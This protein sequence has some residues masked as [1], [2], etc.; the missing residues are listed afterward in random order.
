MSAEGRSR[1][2]AGGAA[3]PGGSLSTLA[4]ALVAVHG[5]S[6]QHRL[7]RQ[8]AQR[9][10]LDRFAGE[11]VTAPAAGL[12]GRLPPAP[13]RR[14]SSSHEVVR[15][16]RERAR[17]ADLLRLGLTRSRRSARS[18]ARTSHLAAEEQRLG[19]ADTLRTAAEQAREALS[20]DDGA[21]DALGADG[22]GPAGRW[23]SVREHDPQVAGLADRLAEAS[24]PAEPT[25]PP[26]W[27]PTPRAWRPTRPG[28]RRSPSGGPR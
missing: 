3:V 11:P 6:D 16:A 28:W 14:A 23:T 12:R 7:L 17:E 8:E 9:D 25:S 21:A 10:A 13:G 5:Q 18:P 15:S 20:S 26:T 1:A 4:D 24:L 19:F 27:R 22:G 2:Y